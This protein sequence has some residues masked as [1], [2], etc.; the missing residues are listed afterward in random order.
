MP[1]RFK[2]LEFMAGRPMDK[3]EREKHWTDRVTRLREDLEKLVDCEARGDAAE[4][5]KM[6][7]I[8]WAGWMCKPPKW[9]SQYYRELVQKQRLP[10]Q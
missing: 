1:R 3:A 2:G 5:A 8:I 4:A 6:R 9:A 7:L 10:T